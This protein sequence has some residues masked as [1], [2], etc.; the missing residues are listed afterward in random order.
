MMMMLPLY[1][2]LVSGVHLAGGGGGGGDGD[3]GLGGA[4]L[5]LLSLQ[6]TGQGAQP[7][8]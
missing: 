4:M 8:Y 5:Q 1:K 7:P 2:T 6:L 3:G